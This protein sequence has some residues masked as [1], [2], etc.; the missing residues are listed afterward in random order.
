MKEYQV[1]VDKRVMKPFRRIPEKHAR[2]IQ[3]AMG[4]LRVNPHPHDSIK[5]KATGGYRLTVG[6]YRILYTV[7]EEELTVTIYLIAKR[8]DF[9]Y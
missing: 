4:R 9:N 1:I 7:E 8:N 2:Q 6:E 3:E 5:L